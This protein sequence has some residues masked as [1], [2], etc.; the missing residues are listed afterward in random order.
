MKGVVFTE[1]LDWIERCHGVE[2][3]DE[4][5]L[6]AELPHGGAYTTA[7]TYDWREFVAIVD[8]LARRTRTPRA[9]LLRGYGQHLFPV[10]AERFADLVGGAG[11]PFALLA[12]VGAHIAQEVSKLY[13][14][15]ELPQFRVERQPD[16]IVVDY[17][18]TRPLAYLAH[19]MIEGC[20]G[21]FG[22]PVRVQDH[23]GAN[24]RRFCITARE[25][26]PCR[27]TR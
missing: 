3:L 8:A 15:P 2:L 24:R 14:D 20:C 16:G 9:E 23:G 21:Y 4:V 26:A 6:D 11:T 7:G 1:L 18:S 27:T 25:E 10:F 13:P 19:G 17:E 5:L 22:L 12:S